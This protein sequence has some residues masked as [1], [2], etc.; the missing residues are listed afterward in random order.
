MGTTAP[1]PEGLSRRV[2]PAHFVLVLAVAA[3]LRLVLIDRLPQGA[4]IDEVFTMRN[5]LRLLHEPFAP[6]GHTPL[7]REG[8]VETPNLYLYFNA[9]LVRLFGVGYVQ[10]KLFSAIHGI[11]TCGFFY[12]VC[13]R[14]FPRAVATGTALLFAFSHWHVRLSRYG[15]DNA[16]LM[17]TFAGAFWLL[18]LAL[19]RNPAFSLLA[20]AFAG[21]CLYS[22]IAGRA[23]LVSLVLAFAVAVLR[24]RARRN[25]VRLGA[26]TAAAVVVAAPLLLHWVSSPDAAAVRTDELTVF[27]HP[28]PLAKVA[29]NTWRHALMFHVRG[30]A[31]ARDNYPGL[32]ML[33]PLTGV[34]FA[35]GLVGAVR[36]RREG[37]VKTLP[38]LVLVNLAGGVFSISQEGAPYV[39]R[40]TPT[41]IPAMLL[42]GLGLDTL[43]GVVRSRWPALLTAPTALVVP[44]ALAA[45]MNLWSY[46]VLETRNISA[47][48]VM[49]A[50]HRLVGEAIRRTPHDVFLLMPGVLSKPRDAPAPGERHFRVNRNIPYTAVDAEISKLAVLYFSG[51]YDW[52]RDETMNLRESR[53]HWLRSEGMPARLPLP[54]TVVMHPHDQ[55]TTSLLRQRHAGDVVSVEQLQGPGGWMQLCAMTIS[56][57]AATSQ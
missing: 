13:A 20:G 35:G 34:L 22:Y 6:L 49:G 41:L 45:A 54:T 50:E 31:Y 9:M 14:L 38:V 27:S 30:G 51:R 26:Y 15:W 19:E 36:R 44:L 18:L 47:V 21:G 40:V 33:D 57:A 24:S 43:V 53:V 52:R 46:F 4:Y 12:L 2:V 10:L 1:A 39:Y 55:A 32:P 37:W 28:H 11:L 5:T 56:A 7:A 16:F 3:A 48:R 42:A 8:W 23:V 29:V 17:M 25:L